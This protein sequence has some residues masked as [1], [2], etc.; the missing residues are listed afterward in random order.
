MKNDDILTPHYSDEQSRDFWDKVNSLDNN[1][2]IYNLACKLQEL[3][4]K[5]L[6]I[7]NSKT[8]IENKL[9][10]DIKDDLNKLTNTRIEKSL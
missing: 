4:I 7:L 10:K 5:V 9:K 6:N 2:E 1:N 8:S 3:E